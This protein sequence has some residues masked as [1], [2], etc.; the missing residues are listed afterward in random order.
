MDDKYS[1]TRSVK[2]IYG[3]VYSQVLHRGKNRYVIRP[4]DNR[5]GRGLNLLTFF[6]RNN[7][8]RIL[9]TPK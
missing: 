4:T 9:R 6:D 5:I 3:E 2:R 1:V 8:I 7:H